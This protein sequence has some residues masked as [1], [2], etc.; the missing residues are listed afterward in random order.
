MRA[1]DWLQRHAITVLLGAIILFAALLVL[2]GNWPLGA[3]SCDSMTP[4]ECAA[5]QAEQNIARGDAK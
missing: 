2:T 4:S 1:L 3:E 5:Y